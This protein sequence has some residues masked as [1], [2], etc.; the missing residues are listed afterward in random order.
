MSKGVTVYVDTNVAG[1]KM[2]RTFEVDDDEDEETIRDIA[3]STMWDMVNWHYE[4][5]GEV[6]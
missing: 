5:D 3:E 2:E 4:V 1:H 6:Q